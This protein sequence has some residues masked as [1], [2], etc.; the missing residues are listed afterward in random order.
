MSGVSVRPAEQ[1]D[2]GAVRDIYAV[3][4]EKE[5][6][7]FE[8]AAPEVQEM[9]ARWRAVIA[10]NGPWFVA[11]R[12]GSVAGYAY[13]GPYHRRPAYRM[14]LE[15]SVYVH[16]A[17]RGAGVGRVLLDALIDAATERGFRQMIAVVGDAENAASV[18]L[19]QRAGFRKVGILTNVG[20]KF[21]A[22]RDV[23]LMQRDLGDGGRAPPLD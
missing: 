20:W 21:G 6:G 19:H 12:D 7:S 11:E 1:T 16:S 8:L 13:A 4:V 5:T 2:M 17:H 10:A 23:V 15:C 14:T 3:S 9:V 22:W 18:A